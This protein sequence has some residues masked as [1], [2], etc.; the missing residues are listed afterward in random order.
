MKH[1]SLITDFGAKADGTTVNTT[2]IQA[3]VDRCFES[4]GGTVLI[5]PGIFVTGTIELKSNVTLELAPGATLRASRNPADYRKTFP[6]FDGMIPRT[7]GGT[8]FNF[9]MDQF[10]IYALRARDVEIRGSGTIDAQGGA[11]YRETVPGSGKIQA[12]P[13]RPGPTIAFIGC[14]GV[15]LKDF[16]LRDNPMFGIALMQSKSVMIRGIRL[17]TN[18]GFINGDGI[19]VKSSCDVIIS[20][21]EIDAQDDALCFYSDFWDW[22]GAAKLDP[23]GGD[24][25]NITVSNCI[26]SSTWNG[27][28]FGYTGS[29]AIEQIVCSNIIVK[30]AHT[31]IDFICNG[32]YSGFDDGKT[33]YTGS[34]IEKIHVSNFI[35]QNAVWGIRMNVQPEVSSEAGIRDIMFANVRIDSQNG[36]YLSGAEARPICNVTFRDVQLTVNGDIRNAIDTPE[37]IPIFIGTLPFRQAMVLRKTRQVRFLNSS[38]IFPPEAGTWPLELQCEEMIPQE[39]QLEFRSR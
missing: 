36:C 29:G 15:S 8:P 12:G 5:L 22:G 26:L 31:A 7:G 30:H 34:K 1:Y 37:V 11:F 9:N 20:D 16:T 3:A 21:C 33:K 14:H 32:G 10:L 2:A 6:D 35:V 18:P 13:W 39:Y 4:G 25:R 38:V 27:I 24:C 19:H 17:L 23:M 28:R